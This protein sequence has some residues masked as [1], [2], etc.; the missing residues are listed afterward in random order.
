LKE[1]RHHLSND[2]AYV[3]GGAAVGLW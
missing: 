1:S 3:H 2:Q